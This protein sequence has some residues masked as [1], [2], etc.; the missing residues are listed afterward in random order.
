MYL[1]STEKVFKRQ[2]VTALTHQELHQASFYYIIL[3]YYYYTIT[4]NIHIDIQYRDYI[5]IE[6]IDIILSK[7]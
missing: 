1:G 7:Y 4:D 6:L 5:I 3:Y 2:R